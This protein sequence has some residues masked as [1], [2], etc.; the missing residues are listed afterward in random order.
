MTEHSREGGRAAPAPAPAGGD[1]LQ[2]GSL[3]VDEEES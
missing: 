3:T 2:I 1:G